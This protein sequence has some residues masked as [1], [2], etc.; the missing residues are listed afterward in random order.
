MALA[1]CMHFV[2]SLAFSCLQN[3]Q[4]FISGS[5][6][7]GASLMKIF[8]IRQTM[9]PTMMKPMTALMNAP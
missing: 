4:V 7:G 8:E 2:A 9:K 6:A 1:Q 5:G 3:G